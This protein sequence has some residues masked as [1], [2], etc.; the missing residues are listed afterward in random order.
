MQRTFREIQ[1]EIIRFVS[2]SHVN[3][4]R[5]Y[6]HLSV[7]KSTST[8]MRCAKYREQIQKYCTAPDHSALLW[9]FISNKL[10]SKCNMFHDSRPC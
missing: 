3:V 1:G 9:R 5:N 8:P 2:E 7:G 6:P 10:I 4:F